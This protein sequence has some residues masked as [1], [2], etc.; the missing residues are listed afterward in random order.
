MGRPRRDCLA[1]GGCVDSDHPEIRALAESIVDPAA[2]D[3]A[4]AIALYY[5][6]RDE[7][8]YNPYTPWDSPESMMA[9][10]T[11]DVGE[12]WC[13]PKAILMAALCRSQGIPARLG[14]ADVRNHLSTARLRAM[15]K[16][17]VFYYH[18]YCSIHLRGQ[19]VMSTPAFNLGLCER[20]GLK[21]LEFDGIHDSIYHPFDQEG[22]RHMEYLR[23]RGEYADLPFD[24]M[25]RVFRREYPAMFEEDTAPGF[26]A[27]L[28]PDASAWEED[29]AEETGSQ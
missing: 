27:D 6:V 2:G 13:V 28:H 11:L 18:G 14:Y 16:T 29:V 3:M 25:M 22:N 12:G 24:D 7:I 1:P 19:W 5:W 20:F 21:P 15:M 10:R 4:N 8:R 9:S 26:N 17:D 23:Y